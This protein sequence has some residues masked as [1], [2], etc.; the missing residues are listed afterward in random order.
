MP[1]DTSSHKIEKDGFDGS[2]CG[3]HALSDYQT[4][5]YLMPGSF[6]PNRQTEKCL[7]SLGAYIRK[8]QYSCCCGKQGVKLRQSRFSKAWHL[9]RGALFSLLGAG[10]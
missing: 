3:R 2:F 5:V 10:Q 8:L 7:L 4:F 9:K 6:T 1:V